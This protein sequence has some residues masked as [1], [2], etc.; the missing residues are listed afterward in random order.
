MADDVAHAAKA[1]TRVASLERQLEF[2]HKARDDAR[3]QAEAADAARAELAATNRDLIK[4][5][6]ELDARELDLEDKIRLHD[7]QRASGTATFARPRSE[8][9]RLN[10]A[11]A[12]TPIHMATANLPGALS[13]RRRAGSRD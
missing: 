2:A 3:R 9:G 5:G 7:R 6:R 8:W 11:D 12:I 4:K 13:A 1:E 10:A